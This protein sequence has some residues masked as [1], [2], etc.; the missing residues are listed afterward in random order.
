MPKR[1]RQHVVETAS[2]TKLRTALPADWTISDTIEDYGVDARVEAF[3]D[4]SATG[5]AFWVQLKGTDEP[6]LSRAL[7]APLA[8]T[9]LNYMAAQAD[10]VLLVR[11]HGPSDRLYG[12]WLHRTALELQHPDQKTVTVTWT[13]EHELTADSAAALTWETQ[14]FRRISHAAPGAISA[15]LRI[16]ASPAEDTAIRLATAR[17]FRRVGGHISVTDVDDPDVTIWLSPDR[18]TV[19]MAVASLHIDMSGGGLADPV[20]NIA[21]A[22][23][24]CLVSLGRADVAAALILAEPTASL[25]HDE[26]I[27]LHLAPAFVRA[28]RLGDAARLLVRYAQSANGPRILEAALLIALGTNP[29]QLDSTADVG[30]DLLGV[31]EALHS[32][33]RHYDGAAAYYNAGNFLFSVLGDAAQARNAFEMALELRPDY[34]VRPYFLAELAAT[35]FETGSYETAETLYRQVLTHGGDPHTTGCLADTLAHQGHYQA[36]VTLLDDNADDLSPAWQLKRHALHTLLTRT[37][38]TDQTRNPNPPPDND[39]LT[40]EQLWQFD[41][42]HPAG[43]L[44]GLPTAALDLHA[45]LDAL[46]MVCAFP[47]DIEPVPWWELLTVAHRLHRHDILN[48]AAREASRR[49]GDDFL[50]GLAH[51]SASDDPADKDLAAVLAEHGAAAQSRADYTVRVIDEDGTFTAYTLD[52]AP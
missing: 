32:A 36:A 25:L 47:H 44:Q 42:L 39:T 9:A 31:A 15:R 16:D 4:G 45:L 40:A 37:G 10:P 12:Q 43:Y 1:P 7:K 46:L 20:P 26:P 51:L 8:V 17:L 13:D 52:D 11:H 28:G 35:H 23:A 38:I 29:E 50:V 33:G 27:A 34:A 14:R 3:I 48:S 41:A 30:A 6:D 21:A 19:D 18:L 2:R 49:L 24:H 5:L 22:C